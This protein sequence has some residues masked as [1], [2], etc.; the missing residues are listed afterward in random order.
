MNGFLRPEAAATLKRWRE[1]IAALAVALLGLWI[2]QQ[3]GPILGGFGLILA[4]LAL[5][6]LIPAIRRA[7]FAASG[8]GP[9]VVQVDERCILYMGPHHGGSVAL[10]ELA[11]ISARRTPDG[12]LTWVLVE[13]GQVLTIPADAKGG[14]ALFDAFTALPGLS[15]QQVLAARENP[16]PGTH[17]LWQ[18]T[19]SPALTR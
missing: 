2:A 15:A 8:E 19:Q 9:G 1:V 16:H 6:V 7:R 4:L 17:R 12:Q 3:P 11:L 13:G 18:R 14:E 10:D 5:A